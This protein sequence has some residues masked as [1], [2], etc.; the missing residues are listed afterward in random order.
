MEYHGIAKY[1]GPSGMR[2]TYPI[3]PGMKPPRRIIAPS[4]ET[5]TLVSLALVSCE[6]LERDA[7]LDAAD[8]LLDL[9]RRERDRRAAQRLVAQG[10]A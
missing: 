6:V 2:S 7:Q 1:E 10:R 4:G 3:R 9:E 8:R 5:R